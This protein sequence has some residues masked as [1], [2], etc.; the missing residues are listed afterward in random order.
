MIGTALA[1]GLLAGIGFWIAG[2]PQSLL[3][4][5]LTYLLSFMPAGPPFVWGPVALW[6][7]MQGSVWWGLF[8]ALWGPASRQ[9]YWQLPTPISA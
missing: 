6:L 8:I 1:Q 4:S 7:L 2:A 9:Q 5:C 3:L